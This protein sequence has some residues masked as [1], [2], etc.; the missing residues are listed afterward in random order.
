[1]RYQSLG[2]SGLLVSVV[3]LGCNNFGR[4]STWTGR[5]RAPLTP[6]SAVRHA[7]I[8]RTAQT[9]CGPAPCPAGAGQAGP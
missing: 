4:G 3:G 5:G 8:S 9:L 1:M 2:S 6:A 7:D